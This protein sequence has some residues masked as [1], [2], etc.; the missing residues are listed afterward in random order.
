MITVTLPVDVSPER[1]I[2]A[3]TRLDH[4]MATDP[5]WNGHGCRVNEPGDYLV[6]DSD[7]DGYNTTALYNELRAVLYD[8]RED[9]ENAPIRVRPCITF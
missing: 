3:L 5:S 6:V 4:I 1:R 7:N 2:Y 8:E 9:D